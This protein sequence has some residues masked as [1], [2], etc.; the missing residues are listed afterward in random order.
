[1]KKKIKKYK[2]YVGYVV[3]FAYMKKEEKEKEK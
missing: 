3:P 1:L 2:G